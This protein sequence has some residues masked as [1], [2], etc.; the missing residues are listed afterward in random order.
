[1]EKKHSIIRIEWLSDEIIQIDFCFSEEDVDKKVMKKLKQLL[2][3][4]IIQY[5][6]IVGMVGW[7]TVCNMMFFKTKETF[8]HKKYSIKNLIHYTNKDIYKNNGYWLNGVD[9]IIW[10][11]KYK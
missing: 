10:N 4:L 6:G 7:E 1:V 2:N 5:N 11:E 3:D 9:E 8:P